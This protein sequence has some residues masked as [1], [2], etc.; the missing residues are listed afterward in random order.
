MKIIETIN[1]LF[2]KNKYK[3][4]IMDL[5][6]SLGM[7]TNNTVNSYKEYQAYVKANT[8]FGNIFFKGIC[9]DAFPHGYD[10]STANDTCIWFGSDMA[11]YNIKP[12]WGDSF[13]PIDGPDADK[14]FKGRNDLNNLKSLGVNLIRLYDW[15]P[16]NNHIPFLDYCHK[17]GIQVLVPVS[18]YNLGAFGLPP[19]M[20]DSITSLINS[21]SSGK[22]YHPAIYGITIGSETDQ[23]A[24][25]PISY[26]IAYTQKWAEIESVAYNN[27]RK[28]PIG[29][30][31][32]FATSGPDWSGK[33]PCFGYLDKL[34]PTLLI[35]NTRDLNK[36][37]MLCPHTYNEASYLYDNA[38]NSGKGWIDLAW[39]QYNL[40]I[41]ICEI[42]CSR[43]TRPDYLNVIQQQLV[44]SIQY[45]NKNRLLGICYFQYCDKVWVPNTTEGSFG[46][47][48]NSD[49]ITDVVRYGP[50]DFTHNDGFPCVNNS[51]NIQ[52]LQSNDALN[53]LREAYEENI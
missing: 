38:E 15:D 28:V 34:L 12:L 9:Y 1:N 17:L 23:Q 25:I 27:F 53:I 13:S 24:N 41:L 2:N 3:P 47:V 7:K 16:R 20:T 49:Q 18:N 36:R 10:P 19:D 26:V 35:D 48:G 33:Y 32:S 40:P 50:A 5:F 46:L 43:L 44:K 14:I 4:H 45:N 30:P 42:G 52:I 39:E 31:I 21:F 11:G 6:S 8:I 22:D 29:H 37:L 51:L